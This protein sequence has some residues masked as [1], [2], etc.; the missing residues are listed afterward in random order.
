MAVHATIC[1]P[2]LSILINRLRKSRE[3]HRRLQRLLI[4]HHQR[5]DRHLSAFPLFVRVQRGAPAGG[6]IA[7][8]AHGWRVWGAISCVPMGPGHLHEAVE[9]AK[10]QLELHAV[11]Q[12]FVRRLND[13]Q[14]R[15]FE[16][17]NGNIQ[18]YDE[19]IDV[20]EAHQKLSAGLSCLCAA[21]HAALIPPV[22][23]LRQ[24]R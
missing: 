8:A 9:D 5:R 15:V 24:R 18:N 22:P 4:G 13:V 20:N 11:D 14:A 21:G 6:V 3:S 2:N 12:R 17:H 23:L 19:H 1:I 7:A 10:L 16:R